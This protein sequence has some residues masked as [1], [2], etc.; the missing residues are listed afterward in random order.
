MIGVRRGI[1]RLTSLFRNYWKF[2]LLGLL[3]LGL[4]VTIATLPAPHTFISATVN[5]ESVEQTLGVRPMTIVLP[6]A[7][8]F[9]D[10]SGTATCRTS[11]DPVKVNGGSF[12]IYSAP[13]SGDLEITI[14]DKGLYDTYRIYST[15][16]TMA[17]SAEVAEFRRTC[18]WEGRVRLPVLGSL[19]VGMAP[20]VDT[21]ERLDL[22]LG[23]SLRIF[24]R[25]SETALGGLLPMSVFS[26]ILAMEPGSL[27]EVQDVQIIPGSVVGP[28]YADRKRT[29][30]DYALWRGF[31]D[32]ELGPGGVTDKAMIVSATANAAT[33]LLQA[34]AANDRPNSAGRKDS[35]S[36]SL[37]ARLAGDPAM[38]LFLVTISFIATVLS[39]AWQLLGRRPSDGPAGMP[40]PEINAAPPLPAESAAPAP[41]PVAAPS[42]ALPKAQ[43]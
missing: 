27:Y 14:N 20:R 30:G 39:A 25:S 10:S 37:A 35:L 18:G 2:K 32:V 7:V 26:P 12:V 43:D 11:A 22:V 23:G 16:S 36:L 5:S 17:D 13:P 21:V 9:D 4:V 24:G 29:E 38:Q 15:R 33:V 42:T 19:V 31:V 8:H 6:R 28:A 3:F 41:A 1:A 34:P 40:R